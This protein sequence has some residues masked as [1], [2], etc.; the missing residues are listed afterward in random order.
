V[1]GA[2]QYFLAV[3]EAVEDSWSRVSQ[4]LVDAA[5]VCSGSSCATTARTL[6]PGQFR[7]WVQAKSGPGGAWSAAMDFTVRR[8][9][10]PI[11]VSP[12]GTLSDSTP[13]Y[14]WRPTGATS[15]LLAVDED[16]G[17][18]VTRT[19]YQTST[20]C[21]PNLCL[22]APDTALA[23][24]HYSW[25]VQPADGG[26]QSAV[27]AFHIVE[28]PLPQGD[29]S[30]PEQVHFYH[31]DPLGS[32]RMVTGIDGSVLA[33]YDYFPFGEQIP[34]TLSGRNSVPG[35]NADAG[36][37]HRFTGKLRDFEGGS[38][39]LD[40]FGA[41]YFSGAMGRFMSTDP[42]LNL[43]PTIRDPQRWNRYGYVRNNPLKFVD[44]DGRDI[45]F[46]NDTEEG[47]KKALAMITQNLRPAEASNIGLRTT[48]KG[49]Y[50]AYVK[51]RSAPSKHATANYGKLVV[52][53]DR[54]VV[55]NV[56]GRHRPDSKDLG[57]GVQREAINA[58]RTRSAT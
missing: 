58:A 50:E 7:W 16:G 40:Y 30:L 22:A 48:K 4:L 11:L 25:F 32:V 34:S 18:T 33:R 12:G 29:P 17:R 2:T 42:L 57:R 37:K 43:K 13:T 21:T 5:A 24:G 39:P 47:R 38:L 23:M 35:Y 41:R 20:S 1:A 10:A 27:K 49:G 6:W 44:P 53:A 55:A 26:L 8:A 52:L 56:G 54:S 31:S 9:V 14:A 19:W 28:T 46:V 3:D 36:N 45:G 15:Y 51:D